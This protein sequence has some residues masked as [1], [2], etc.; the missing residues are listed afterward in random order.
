MTNALALPPRLSALR[1][2]YCSITMNL[3]PIIPETQSA[4]HQHAQAGEPTTIDDGARRDRKTSFSEITPKSA[5]R[6]SMAFKVRGVV[7]VE[8]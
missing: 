4:N 6:A 3:T 8:K 1:F 2:A 7:V 5:R